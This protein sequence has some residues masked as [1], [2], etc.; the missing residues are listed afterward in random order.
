MQQK[1]DT[2]CRNLAA[3]SCHK[4]INSFNPVMIST[5]SL[6]QKQQNVN[7]FKHDV[8]VAPHSIVT[9]ILHE[10]H[11]SKGHQGTIHTFEAIRRFYW[12]LNYIKT[13]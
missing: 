3:K 4:N 8:I 9:T 10:F 11:N 2:N 6:L 1:K 7:G 12:C 13:L 5:G